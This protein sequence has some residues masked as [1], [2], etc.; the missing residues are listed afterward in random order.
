M[1]PNKST[2]GHLVKMECLVSDVTAI[3]SPDRAEHAILGMIFAKCVFWP[4]QALFMVAEPFCDVH[5]NFLLSPN[6]F[7]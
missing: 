4:N 1:S 3:R 7:T 6:D 2:E 5:R